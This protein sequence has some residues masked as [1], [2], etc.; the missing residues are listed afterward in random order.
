MKDQAS[1]AAQKLV[2]L[3]RDEILAR[4]WLSVRACAAGA[5]QMA[6]AADTVVDGDDDDEMDMMAGLG[7][8][9]N[10]PDAAAPSLLLPPVGGSTLLPAPPHTPLATQLATSEVLVAE[11]EIPAGMITALSG[12]TPDEQAA[13]ARELDHYNKKPNPGRK[14]RPLAWWKDWEKG[15]TFTPYLPQ[16]VKG[17]FSIPAS[18]AGNER[19]F[20]WMGYI[21]GLRRA[22]LDYDMLGW[23]SFIAAFFRDQRKLSEYLKSRGVHGLYGE[24]GSN[25]M[26]KKKDAREAERDEWDEER[27]LEREVLEHHN[28]LLE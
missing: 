25:A 11:Q 27:M 8:P 22:R 19:Q 15:V 12:M 17:V 7:A 28:D 20:S 5:A 10:V 13:F 14:Q 23:M 26:P 6:D 18:Q 16:I 1:K 9:G 24:N 3:Y 2:T 4:M 21:S